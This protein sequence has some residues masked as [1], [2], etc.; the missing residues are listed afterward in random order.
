MKA[1]PAASVY[2]TSSPVHQESMEL[3]VQERFEELWG[4]CDGSA[5]LFERASERTSFRGRQLAGIIRKNAVLA[6]IHARSVI[7]V[8][9]RR[10]ICHV[11]DVEDLREARP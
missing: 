3:L 9:P 6:R 10:V 1:S 2:F 7:G 4:V 5:R 8:L 11:D